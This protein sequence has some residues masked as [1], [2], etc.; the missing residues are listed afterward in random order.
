M[1]TKQKRRPRGF[2][3]GHT[4]NLACPHRDVTCCPHCAAAHEEIVE[5]YGQHF[6]IADRVERMEML[7]NLAA[8]T[9]H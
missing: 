9:E 2:R 7:A 4:G 1:T 5:I 3:E 6:W 8:S